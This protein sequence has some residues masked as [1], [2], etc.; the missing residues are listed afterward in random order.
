MPTTSHHRKDGRLKAHTICPPAEIGG[1][2]PEQLSVAEFVNL[3]NAVARE[4]S[5][6]A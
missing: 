2:R 1:R 4:T 6:T 3:T 5:E